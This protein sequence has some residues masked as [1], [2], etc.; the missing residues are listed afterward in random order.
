[1]QSITFVGN[2]GNDPEL[3][4]SKNGTNRARFTVAVSEGQRD[5]DNEKTHWLNVTAFGTLGENVAES[6]S[7]GTRVVVVGRFDTYQREVQID[8]EDKRLGMVSFIASAVGPDLRWATAEVKKVAKKNDG[9][10]GSADFE[11]AEEKPKAKK[12]K[13]QKKEKPA[14]VAA[15]DDF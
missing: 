13:S 10:T 6:L 2:L 3:V 12:G 11:E 5:S 8:G 15:S 1:M 4:E 7:K 14:P 9:P